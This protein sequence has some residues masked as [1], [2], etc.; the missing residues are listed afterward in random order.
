MNKELIYGE[1]DGNFVNNDEENL[2]GDFTSNRTETDARFLK[3]ID[4][5][6]LNDEDIIVKDGTH[7][8][9]RI[10]IYKLNDDYIYEGID[11]IQYNLLAF[12]EN[13]D[14]FTLRKYYTFAG[15]DYYYKTYNIKFKLDTTYYTQKNRITVLDVITSARS[16]TST[17]NTSKLYHR[18]LFKT[19]ENSLKVITSM[20]NN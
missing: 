1:M 18:S 17:D 2:Y 9:T 5:N 20:L 10:S 7:F 16:Y 6:T 14:Y 13:T 19:K 15:R 11:D 3:I 12:D 8:D 4:L